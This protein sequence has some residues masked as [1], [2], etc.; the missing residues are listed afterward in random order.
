MNHIAS[1]KFEF[2][3]SHGLFDLESKKGKA[4]GGYEAYVPGIKAPFIFQTSMEHLV[5]SMY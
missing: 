2:M 1:E 4:P 5:I 3:R